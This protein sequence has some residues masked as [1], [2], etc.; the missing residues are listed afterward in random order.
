MEAIRPIVESYDR[1]IAAIEADHKRRLTSGEAVVKGVRA[2]AV[3]HQKLR[4]SLDDGTDL[5]ARNLL[6]A[7]D[8]IRAATRPQQ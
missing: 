5:D 7:L 2:W 6:A 1:E 3:E 8:E 4:A